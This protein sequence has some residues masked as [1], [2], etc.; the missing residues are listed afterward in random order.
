[1]FLISPASR[2]SEQELCGSSGGVPPDGQD[3]HNECLGHDLWIIL[4]TR[5]I[6]QVLRLEVDITAEEYLVKMFAVLLAM[7]GLLM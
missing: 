3:W 5:L 1:M 4:S 7:S 6:P 2:G